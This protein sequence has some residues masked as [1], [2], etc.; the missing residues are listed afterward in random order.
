MP[1][2][3]TPR[4]PENGRGMSRA[5]TIRLPRC[6]GSERGSP[7]PLQPVTYRHDYS[8]S[9][10]LGWD[11]QNGVAP[12]VSSSYPDSTMGVPRPRN[13]DGAADRYRKQDG[14]YDGRPRAGRVLRCNPSARPRFAPRACGVSA[15]PAHADVRVRG[16]LESV[17]RG[18]TA[19]RERSERVS[20]KNPMRTPNRKCEGLLTL[21]N[22]TPRPPSHPATCSLS[23][24]ISISGSTSPRPIHLPD[25]GSRSP[26]SFILLSLA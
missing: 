21:P 7:S 12:W 24:G 2:P 14:P 9:R 22:K 25:D 13:E 26:C 1:P 11:E 16:T 23:K 6:L 20:G 8:L 10:V 15:P 4:I 17:D 18:R 5:I 3:H 19:S